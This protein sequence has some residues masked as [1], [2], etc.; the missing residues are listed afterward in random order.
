MSCAIQTRSTTTI[1]VDGSTSTS[2][3]A[4]E[5]LYAGDGPTPA[6]LYLPGDR[7][8][9]YEPTVPIVPNFDSANTTA[10]AKVTPTSGFST[11]K[12]RR[13]A[14]ET[15]STGVPSFS[16]TAIVNSSLARS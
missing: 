1:P 14:N 16:A 4:A 5:Y 8:G 15:F 9:V 2:A 6:P 13:S 3:T 10:S 7:G 12:A 11:S